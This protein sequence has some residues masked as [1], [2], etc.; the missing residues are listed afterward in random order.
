MAD[1]DPLISVVVPCYNEAG[2]LRALFERVDRALED[3]PVAFELILVDDGSSDGT[4]QEMRALRER[5]GRVRFL[6]LSRNFGHEVASTAGIEHACGDAVVL[7]DADLQDPPEVIPEM[8][9]LWRGGHDVVYAVRE[10]R[11]GESTLKRWTSS[12]FYRI[13]RRL[14]R[15]P[16]PVD[17]GDFRLMTRP[18]VDAFLRM[19]ERNRFVRGMVAWT[20]YSTAAV[21]YRRDPRHS[22]ETKYGF[23]SLLVLA[24]DAV[25]AFSAAPLRLISVT[26][27]F[28]TLLSMVAVLVVVYQKLILGIP[29][30]GYAFLVTGVFFLG[31]VQILLLGAIGE[32]VGRIFTETQGRPLYLIRESGGLERHEA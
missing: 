24:L 5:D 9:A 23:W 27:L 19:R 32:Y 2:N 7:I 29:I 22:G 4:A 6:R 18:V 17:T 8:I 30:P 1:Q 10:E 15:V 26:G 14:S 25:T 3:S 12:L 21:T 28:V 11:R 16:I 20:G 31:G 13:L